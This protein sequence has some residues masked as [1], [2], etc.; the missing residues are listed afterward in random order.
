MGFEPDFGVKVIKADDD[1]SETP[2]APAP[3]EPELSSNAAP[4]RAPATAAAATVKTG[5]AGVINC[6]VIICGIWE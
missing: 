1:E 5:R 4:P 3:T 6:P 2:L